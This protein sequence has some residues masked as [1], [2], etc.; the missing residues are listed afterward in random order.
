MKIRPIPLPPKLPGHQLALGMET[1]ILQAEHLKTMAKNGSA[2]SKVEVLDLV[3]DY[4]EQNSLVGKLPFKNG[5]PGHDW[6]KN[7]CK[8]HISLKKR[9]GLEKARKL[10]TSDPFVIYEFYDLLEREIKVLQ[11]EDKPSH[12]YNLDETSDPSRIKMVSGIGQKAHRV[13][14]GTGRENT[15]VWHAAMQ[16]EKFCLL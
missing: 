12:I 1:E 15:S 7:F 14:E 8:R 11:L 6:Y 5:R 16:G 2:L 10:N 4:V 13:Q 9:E 3:K